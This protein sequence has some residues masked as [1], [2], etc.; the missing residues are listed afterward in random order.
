VL[1]AKNFDTFRKL[2]PMA[3]LSQVAFFANGQAFEYF[4]HR[5]LDNSLGEI[6]WA[7]ESALIELNKIIPAFLRRLQ[8]DAAK[9]YR[10]YR[11]QIR[12][13]TISALKKIKWNRKIVKA[14]SKA[15]KLIEYD[16][17]GEDKII[18]GLI[19]PQT[20]IPFE[21]ILKAV[22]KMPKKDKS[23]ILKSALK[24]RQARWYK[25]PR[26]FENTYL[27]FEIT[28]NLGAWRDLHR[29]RMQT[30]FR[31][32][33]N[34]FHGFDIPPELKG[35]KF[36]TD[37][38]KAIKKAENLFKKVYKFNPEIAQYC[39]TLA[40]K[41]RFI[42]FQNMRS[43]FWESELRTIAQG[44]PDYRKIEHEKI[45]LVKKTYPLVCKH[46]L[47]DMNEYAF[48]RRG[49][50]KKIEEKER[51]LTKQLSKNHP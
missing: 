18:A 15:V 20:H 3:T 24:N 39:P 12:K 7:G 32:N 4:I 25:V 46:L 13:Q 36:E 45:K 38:I 31:E 22:K 40:H 2:L 51:K 34:I 8:S 33:F 29:H 26:A 10:K 44:H 5:S 21:K 37:Y 27:R 43:F 28:V 42:Q 16:K 1:K 47:A 48:A 23:L 41:V 50:A 6:R 19:Y 11:N 49:T 17:G 35:T 14:K 30:Q 9:D